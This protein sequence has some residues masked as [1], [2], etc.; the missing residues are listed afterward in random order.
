[1]CIRDRV[2]AQQHGTDPL[3]LKN[4]TLI[5]ILLGGFITNF[6][7]CVRLN[8]KNKTY[9]DYFSS[10]CPKVINN[11]SFSFLAGLLWFLQFQFYGMGSSKLPP[12]MAIFG[13]S[14]LM[15][16]NIAISNIWGIAPVSYTHL[17][18]YKRQTLANS[19]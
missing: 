4:V 12:A 18:V 14:I 16:L 7:Y 15:A 11:V 2:I 19:R 17:D 10:A 1:M 3:Y 5:Y 6:V 8:F 9:R 13:W